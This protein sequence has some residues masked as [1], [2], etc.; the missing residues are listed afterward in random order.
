MLKDIKGYEGLYKID[1][2]GNVYSL[3]YNIIRKQQKDIYGYMRVILIKNKKAKNIAVH[4]LVAQ[5]FLNDFDEKLQ[6][7]HKDENK[8]NNNYLNL[9]MCTAKYN[10]N[11]GTRNKR[12]SKTNKGVINK[13][14]RN[15]PK[16]EFK[17]GMIPWNKNKNTF[18]TA[19]PVICVELNKRFDSIVLAQKEMG[20]HT[21]N[22]G[23]ACRKKWRSLG[24]HWRYA[25]D[26]DDNNTL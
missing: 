20:G 11:Y 7:N 25:D 12:I 1:E 3:T 18:D 10:S 23:R 4:R 19:R 6:V 14:K 8:T 13:G 9:E 21:E 24:Y 5:A 17:K 2:N 15:S 26:I 22:I 16:T